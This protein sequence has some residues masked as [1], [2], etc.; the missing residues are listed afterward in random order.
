MPNLDLESLQ[1][2]LALEE[3][4]LANP[5]A[6][7]HL[8]MV[9]NDV[10]SSIPAM[11]SLRSPTTRTLMS[12]RQN[13]NA[14]GWISGQFAVA[15]REQQGMSE[16]AEAAEELLKAP[17]VKSYASTVT[18]ILKQTKEAVHGYGPSSSASSSSCCNPGDTDIGE[19]APRSSLEME[20]SSVRSVFPLVATNIQPC[21]R[22]AYIHADVASISDDVASGGNQSSTL[23]ADVK[24]VSG[25]CFVLPKAET[26]TVI[27]QVDA[28]STLLVAARKS[29]HQHK[30]P[31]DD[32]RHQYQSFAT[33]GGDQVEMSEEDV[34]RHID[35]DLQS[36]VAG[37][38]ST[39]SFG[40]LQAAHEQKL[41]ASKSNNNIGEIFSAAD[42][43]QEA[44]TQLEVGG[45]SLPV[46]S[47]MQQLLDEQKVMHQSMADSKTEYKALL[48]GL[49][50]W[51][52]ARRDAFDVVTSTPVPYT[53]LTGE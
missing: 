38:V 50:R 16:V 17:L 41:Q 26:E 7:H 51:Q 29:Q 11:E 2:I 46:K 9:T 6:A 39:A 22:Q 40:G 27:A 21:G 18:T 32:H 36:C 48:D 19:G 34:L 1:R 8:D 37:D 4:T 43:G 20:D 31:S 35:Q 12:I 23:D 28:P 14:H 53:R 30:G 47:R 52:A 44:G 45:P 49:Q 3:D 33:R 10:G 15:Q 25:I 13:Q 24:L 42:F 5:S